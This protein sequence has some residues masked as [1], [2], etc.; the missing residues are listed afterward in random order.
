MRNPFLV[1]VF[2]N[3]STQYVQQHGSNSNDFLYSIKKNRPPQKRFRRCQKACKW[4][5]LPKET[6][7]KSTIPQKILLT[8]LQAFWHLRNLSRGCWEKTYLFECWR[9][10]FSSQSFTLDYLVSVK[11]LC[12]LHQ[13]MPFMVQC[14]VF[15]FNLC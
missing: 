12:T 11:F 7:K 9:W 6:I 5:K 8:H 13:M 4:V 14:I 2:D 1:H 15:L 10:N 3:T